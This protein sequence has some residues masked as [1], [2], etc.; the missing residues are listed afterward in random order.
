MAQAAQHGPLAR[1]G[2]L[3][4]TDGRP[5]PKENGL[6][7]VVL[8][9]GAVAAVTAI[10]SGLHI[11]SAWAGL[12]GLLAGGWSQLNSATTGQRFVTVIGLGAAGVGLYLGLANGGFWN[13]WLD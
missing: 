7:V 2:S 1:A 9:V 8:V 10:F 4:N 6:A 11:V 3:M 13:G 5:H 12:A